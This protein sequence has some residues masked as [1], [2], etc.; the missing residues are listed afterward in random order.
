MPKHPLH[1]PL[2]NSP[3]P[4][5]PIFPFIPLLPNKGRTLPSILPFPLTMTMTARRTPFSGMTTTTMHSR[6]PAQSLRVRK[7]QRLEIFHRQSRLRDA[8]ESCDR[9]DDVQGVGV[10]LLVQEEFWGF[11]EFE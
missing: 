8:V 10:V 1:C 3:R 5:L 4:S 6:R 2:H 11:A 9:V 7:F